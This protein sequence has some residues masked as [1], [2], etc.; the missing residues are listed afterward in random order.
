MSSDAG[1]VTKVLGLVKLLGA[2]VVAGLLGGLVLVP[3]FGSVGLAA[4]N[5]SSQV[6]SKELMEP[7]LPQKSDIYADDG[8]RI[9]SFYYENRSPVTLAS[10]APIMQKAVVAIEDNR[11]F[12]HGAIDIKGTIRALVRNQANGGQVQ[13]GSS[14]T[15]Q[16]VKNVLFETAGQPVLA[17]EQTLAR[18]R[19]KA[20]ITKAQAALDAARIAQNTTIAPN[21]TRKIQE[22]RYAL[23]VE[24][25]N[26]KNEILTKYL[27]IAFFGHQTYGIE[28]AAMRFFGV[29]AS[30]LN[31]TQAATLAGMVNNANLYDP[32]NNPV[33]TMH[34]RNIV[35]DQMAQYGVI[36]KTEVKADK[37]TPLGLHPK[38]PGGSCE[39]S[40]Y[41]YFCTYVQN[42]IL[43]NPA[44]GATADVRRALLNTGGLQIHTTLSLKAQKGA[45]NAINNFSLGGQSR[46]V[47]E[48]MVQPGTGKVLAIAITKPYG[49]K[50]GQSTIDYAADEAHGGLGGVQA[51]STFKIF[52][53]AAALQSGMTIDKSYSTPASMNLTGYT[54]CSG[55]PTSPW[56]VHNAETSGSTT[57]NMVSATWGSVNTYFAQLERDV[58]LCKVARMAGA[59]GMARG[60]GSPLLQVPTLTLGSNEIDVVHEAAAYAGF[61]ASGKYCHPIA[62]NSI[63][64]GSGKSLAVPS[65]N[66][67]QVVDPAVANEVSVM[68]RGVL[69]SGTAAG[70]TIPGRD[71]AGKTGTNE[72]ENTAMFSGYTPNMA[73]AL[74]YGDPTGPYADPVHAFG[75]KLAPYWVQSMQAALAG[76]PAPNFPNPGNQFGTASGN[77][78]KSSPTCQGNTGNNGQNC[79]GPKTGNPGKGGKGGKGGGPRPGH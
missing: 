40:K 26:T 62:I 33:G 13:G 78:P 6:T 59:F 50:A 51:G 39:S 1:V 69:S 16:Y 63:T 79:S 43:S 67:K 37:V 27:N 64:D 11:F 76:L 18:A 14:L 29:H 58:G 32:I 17:A 49:L 55:A 52:T 42:E 25:H 20:D 71:A 24:Q 36:P 41:G 3:A 65:A 54:D 72:G 70:N 48:S 34:R 2:A 5:A 23:W 45:Q 30:Q 22:L 46:I 57:N 35:L 19:T 74:W 77:P 10:I 28:A 61:A 73:A 4:K 60:N 47:M 31:T 15:Q 68:L 8:S 75:S 56:P 38:S 44:F 9:A 12:S 7:A 53:L 21:L 66:C